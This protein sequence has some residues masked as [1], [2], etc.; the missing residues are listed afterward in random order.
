MPSYS[1]CSLDELFGLIKESDQSAFNEIYERTWEKLY[2]TAKSKL[3]DDQLAKEI[4][5]DIFIDLWE[6]RAKKEVVNISAYLYQSLR[7]KVIDVYRRKKIPIQDIESIKEVLIE[8]KSSDNKCLESELEV[9][10]KNWMEQLPSKRKI[11]FEL[12]YW[13]HKSTKEISEILK[14]SMKTVQNQLLLCKI[15]LKGTVQKFFFILLLFLFG[16]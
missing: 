15:S 7:F 8:T 10:L 1:S 12:Y 11:I 5:Q 13:D 2:I 3:N 14:L 6:K 9:I 16:S 4:V